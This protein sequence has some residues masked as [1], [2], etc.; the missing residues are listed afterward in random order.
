MQLCAVNNYCMSMCLLKKDHFLSMLSF[1][2][3]LQDSLKSENIQFLKL[4]KLTRY[5]SDKYIINNMHF[6]ICVMILIPD[7][8][9]KM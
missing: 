1:T 4:L 3:S 8:I 5:N 6:D 2:P 7:Q 9:H